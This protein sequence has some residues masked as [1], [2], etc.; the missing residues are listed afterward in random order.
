MI[1]DDSAY[2]AHQR[3]MEEHRAK[4]PEQYTHPLVDKFVRMPD[5]TTGNVTRVV[6][7]RFGA[8][9]II[10]DNAERAWPVDALVEV[11]RS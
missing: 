7:S 3:A 5:G 6:Q 1:I 9:A 2:F 8:L 11:P 4:Y 10:D